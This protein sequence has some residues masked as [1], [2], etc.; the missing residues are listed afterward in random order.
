VLNIVLAASGLFVVMLG[1]PAVIRAYHT[2]RFHRQQ[3]R[4][5]VE[6]D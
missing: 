2:A 3:T 6:G 4:L 5:L 1:L